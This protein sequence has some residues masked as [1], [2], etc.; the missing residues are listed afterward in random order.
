MTLTL[1]S[2]MQKFKCIVTEN[3][4]YN[5]E[6]YIYHKPYWKTTTMEV[7][8]TNISNELNY[9]GTHLFSY[10][11][12]LT[13]HLFSFWMKVF[14]FL[15]LNDEDKYLLRQYCTLFRDVV[16]APIWTKF[17]HPKYSSLND[18]ISAINKQYRD[19][20]HGNYIN[21]GPV[22]TMEEFNRMRFTG[23]NKTVSRPSRHS[24]PTL[25]PSPPT[26]IM[27]Q[28]GTH[29][30]AISKYPN[31]IPRNY[32]DIDC[33]I[34]IV[35]ESEA[36]TIIVGGFFC[37]GTR[38]STKTPY[39]T[40]KVELC[41]DTRHAFTCSDFAATNTRNT[42]L[43]ISFKNLTIQNCTGNG[44]MSDI[45]GMWKVG[46]K[47][48]QPLPLHLESV[49]LTGH[50]GSGFSGYGIHGHLK[51]CT[52]ISNQ[53]YGIMSGMQSTII[54]EGHKSIVTSNDIGIS[55]NGHGGRGVF[56]FVFPLTKD[57]ICFENLSGNTHDDL[58]GIFGCC[59]SHEYYPIDVPI[60]LQNLNTT[61]L[62]GKKGLRGT[63]NMV[64]QRFECIIE[65]RKLLIKPEN[66]K[67]DFERQGQYVVKENENKKEK[68]MEQVFNDSWEQVKKETSKQ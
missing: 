8:A 4:I 61:D 3:H 38:P 6:L 64:K 37:F 21:R 58:A 10:D 23:G 42:K 54:F 1:T 52:V 15:N 11:S 30:I 40:N 47:N 59:E 25:R 20:T 32:C 7:N 19:H 22:I 29:V 39:K 49:T 51:N 26:L 36:H 66:I 2:V 17:P 57:K 68:Y 44:V 5:K 50:Q 55:T 46:C 35:G 18:L 31:P 41:K 27:I 63:Y 65:N 13:L 14:S 24:S 62:N 33:P 53:K 9:L 67:E 45:S 16:Q 56:N 43:R 60:T 34:R 28:N 48:Q 12:G